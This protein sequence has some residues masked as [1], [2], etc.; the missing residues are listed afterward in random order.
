MNIRVNTINPGTM[1]TPMIREASAALFSQV[2]VHRKAKSIV[3]LGRIAA[4]EEIAEMSWFLGSQ[5]AAYITGASVAV[6]GG[7]TAGPLY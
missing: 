2:D 6:D 1:D 7:M 4:P 3:P 5:A